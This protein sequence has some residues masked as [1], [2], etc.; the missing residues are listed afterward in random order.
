MFFQALRCEGSDEA[1]FLCACCNISKS[2]YAEGN[3]VELGYVDGT[4]FLCF[5]ETEYTEV[6]ACA[7]EPVEV[8]FLV[9]G[10][11]IV[12]VAAK[13]RTTSSRTGTSGNSSS[14]AGKPYSRNVENPYGRYTSGREEDASYTASFKPDN[15]KR[16]GSSTRRRNS[17]RN[18]D[19]DGQA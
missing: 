5:G 4:V 12:P 9:A 2:A 18:S 19:G 16:T 13:V 8:V 11:F 15:S 14:A 3:A 17:E 1:G 6:K 10:P 7:V